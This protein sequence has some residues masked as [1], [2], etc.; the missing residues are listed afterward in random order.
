MQAIIMSPATLVGIDL[1]KHRFHLQGQ[2]EAGHEVFRKTTRRQ[3][4][5]MLGKLPSRTMM[6]EAC[7]GSPGNCSGMR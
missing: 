3:R 4:M 6:M 7:A 1:G 5:R 2:D